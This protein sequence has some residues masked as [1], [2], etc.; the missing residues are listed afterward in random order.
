MFVKRSGSKIFGAQLSKAE[1]K[2]LDIEV[3]KAIAENGEKY[4]ADWCNVRPETVGQ[5][6]GLTD[7]NGKRIFEGD[8]IKT[9]NGRCCAVSVVRYGTYEPTM[10]FEL[11]ERYAHFRPKE[12]A[13]GFYAITQENEIM[14]LFESRC[15]EVIGNIHDNLELLKGGEQE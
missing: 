6:T 9:N 4:Y 8:I 7:K 12:K 1:E 14:M 10:F 15:I 2:A 11:F 3:R 5:Y 13:C